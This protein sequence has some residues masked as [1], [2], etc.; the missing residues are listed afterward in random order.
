MYN[1][2]TFIKIYIKSVYIVYR[3]SYKRSRPHCVTCLCIICYSEFAYAWLM[4]ADNQMWYT[5][6]DIIE[7]I[8]Y[9]DSIYSQ[10]FPNSH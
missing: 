10:S 5:N 9:Y 7:H 6:I 3:E 1:I 4:N 8:K 2:M